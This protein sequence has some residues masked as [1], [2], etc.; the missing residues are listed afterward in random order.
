MLEDD[1]PPDS[2]D[3]DWIPGRLTLIEERLKA[4]SIELDSL[5]AMSIGH[6][7]PTMVC[8][9]DRP[10]P[11]PFGLLVKNGSKTSFSLSSGMPGPRSETDSSAKFSTRKVR[12]LTMRFSLSVS[13]I[14]SIALTT[15]LVTTC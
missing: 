9:M 6:D 4:M 8:A 10:M 13:A 2:I 1:R 11:M 3:P 14:A 12:M 7:S 15:K 5:K